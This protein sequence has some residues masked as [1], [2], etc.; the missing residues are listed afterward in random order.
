MHLI[1]EAYKNC[2]GAFKFSLKKY[3]FK[4]EMHQR[5]YMFRSVASN[6]L[7]FKDEK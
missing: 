3:L 6:K 7:Q 1:L 2:I 4:L 5:I